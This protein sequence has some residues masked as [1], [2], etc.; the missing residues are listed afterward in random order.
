MH[1]NVHTVLIQAD[2]TWTALNSEKVVQFAKQFEKTHF[3]NGNLA[4]G[5]LRVRVE[6][7]SS[8]IEQQED[9]QKVIQDFVAVI[10]PRIE[11]FFVDS[12]SS[13]T[14]LSSIK[15][16]PA[17]KHLIIYCPSIDYIDTDLLADIRGALIALPSLEIFSANH[18]FLK[19]L[20]EYD[21]EIEVLLK[22][23]RHL[24]IS[25]FPKQEPLKLKYLV[26]KLPNLNSLELE[27]NMIDEF[28]TNQLLRNLIDGKPNAKI[29]LPA[30][31]Y[32]EAI[33]ILRAAPSI[34][35]VKWNNWL[36][37]EERSDYFTNKI[38]GF[39]YYSRLLP[40]RFF[41]K[42][43]YPQ[44]TAFSGH[45]LPSVLM[46]GE[47]AT[48]ERQQ[49]L[50]LFREKFNIKAQP[51]IDHYKLHPAY[52]EDWDVTDP[53]LNELQFNAL[54]EL[55]AL[56]QGFLGYLQVQHADWD[57]NVFEYQGRIWQNYGRYTC[58]ALLQSFDQLCGSFDRIRDDSKQEMDETIEAR[59]VARWKK[60]MKNQKHMV[61]SSL[62]N[63][64]N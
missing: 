28:S 56:L 6:M 12:D 25:F 62:G 35:L 45:K 53:V 15:T 50:E 17:L 3:P 38:K 18:I 7:G 10:A 20:E 34:M 41:H 40:F 51:I 5:Q 16:S 52:F 1:P 14:V 30:E 48:I 58:D 39:Q 11:E 27:I 21:N 22:N 60:L 61:Q 47:Q 55:D 13:L 42:I 4:N 63:L 49:D 19:L 31:T 26:G 2:R 33:K 37:S 43:L 36:R 59:N 46:E 9:V 44:S 24:K 23:V 64:F 54:H 8:H 29:I 32:D 57:S